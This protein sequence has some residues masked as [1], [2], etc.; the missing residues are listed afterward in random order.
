[1]MKVSE[2]IRVLSE[3]DPDKTIRLFISGSCFGYGEKIID[4]DGDN[5]YA[6]N[7]SLVRI[8]VRIDK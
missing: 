3:L 1:M 7:S 4:L 2:L 6:A 8:D 5:I